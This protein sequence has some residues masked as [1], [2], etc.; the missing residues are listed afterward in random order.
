M[1]CCA[2][3]VTVFATGLVLTIGEGDCAIVCAPEVVSHIQLEV[4]EP[5][6]AGA[7]GP[8]GPQGPPGLDL[9]VT[10]LRVDVELVGAIDGANKSFA[11]PPGES[12]ADLGTFGGTHVAVYYNGKRLQHGATR[13]YTV[14]ESGGPGTGF[15]LIVFN[16]DRPAPKPGDLVSA[17]WVNPIP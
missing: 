6:P 8:E 7:I 17:D 3:D 2:N 4:G 13:D 9:P 16:P 5:G 11:L 1:D 15:D 14:Q 12:A 10:A